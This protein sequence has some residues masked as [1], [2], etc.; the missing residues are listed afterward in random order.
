MT[1]VTDDRQFECLIVGGGLIGLLTAREL[2]KRGVDVAVVERGIIGGESSW[3]GGGILSPLYPWRYDDAVTQLARWS[4]QHYPQLASQLL[5]E[6]G[7]DP[8]Y[9]QNGLLIL[10]TEDRQQ[11]CTWAAHW[12]QPLE[13]VTTDTI[14]ALE[15]ALGDA[16]QQAVWL[17]RVGQMRNPRLVQALRKSLENSGVPLMEHTAVTSLKVCDNRIAGVYTPGGGISAR[18]VVIAGGAWSAGLLEDTGL[19]LPVRP[20]RGQMILFRARPGVVQR[21][22]LSRNR[23]VIPRRDGRVLVGSTLEEV[24][25]D[26][27]TTEAALDALRVE[28]FRLIPALAQYPVEHHWA[29]LRPGSPDG[30]PYI[31]SHPVIDG[32]YI[33]TGHFRNG[34]VLGLASAHLLADILLEHAC[35]DLD[36]TPYRLEK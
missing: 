9:Q 15:P 27:T 30:I 23:Y 3:A 18:R 5:T 6:S 33:N 20:V 7:I 36:Q 28:A 19:S 34:V 2:Q 26:K 4:Q 16:P 32:L 29:G 31:T 8:E 35:D 1:K 11:A 12:Q 17:P 10:D 13:V 14:R 22:V 25:F 21:I 24:G